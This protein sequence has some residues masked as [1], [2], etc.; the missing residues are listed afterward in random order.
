MRLKLMILQHQKSLIKAFSSPKNH[1]AWCFLG[2]FK[3]FLVVLFLSPFLLFSTSTQANHLQ[4]ALSPYLQM[5]AQDPVDWHPFN[6]ETLAKA[7]QQNRPILISSGYFSCHW[8]H[9]MQ[10][11]NYHNPDIA[12]LMNQTF[13]NIKIDRELDNELDNYLIQFSRQ[14]TGVTGWPL[15]VLLTP[16]GWSFYA[17]GYVP[18]QALQKRLIKIHELWQANP[19]EIL[20]LAEQALPQSPSQTSKP[21]H[22]NLALERLLQQVQE[23]KDDLSGGLSGS[24]KFPNLPLLLTLIQHDLNPELEAWLQ[25]TLDQMSQTHLMDVVNGGFFRYTIDPEWQTPHYEK[26]LYTQAMAIELYSL[27]AQKYNNPK[28][29]KTAQLTWDYVKNHL[30]NT[31]SQ[32]YLGSQSA[33]DLQ[34][35]EGGDYQYSIQALKARLSSEEFEQVSHTWQLNKPAPQPLGWIAEPTPSLWLSIRS[36][37]QVDPKKIP[38]DH[39][40]LLGWNGLLLSG[41]S[42]LYAVS[43]NKELLKDGQQLSNQLYILLNQKTPPKALASNQQS[44]GEAQLEDWAYTLQGLQNWQIQTANPSDKPRDLSH[45]K[46]RALKRFYQDSTW[47]PTLSPPLPAMTPPAIIADQATPSAVAVWQN[48]DH[49]TCQNG[50]ISSLQGLNLRYENLIHYASYLQP[51]FI[52]CAPVAVA[53]P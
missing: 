6:A 18:P 2:R 5:H 4:A 36:K 21:I 9:V 31:R 12:K 49:K 19:Q 34:G 35:Q 17:F 8:C 32:L 40:A 47:H 51:N 15:H 28:H 29:L 1:Q 3:T 50:R 13:I 43:P 46:A 22:P 25:L 26:M 30:W 14:L 20:K 38:V 11:E 52:E 10:Q 42:Q 53:K 44:I 45:L 27:A 48:L 24:N 39:K 7:R 16:Q 23:A 37:L 33:L 41:I